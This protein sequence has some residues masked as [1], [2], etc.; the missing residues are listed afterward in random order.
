[1][2]IVISHKVRIID[3]NNN[4]NILVLSKIYGRIVNRETYLP[5]QQAFYGLYDVGVNVGMLF[6]FYI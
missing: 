1:M 5:K 4:N 2:L 3:N 6:E